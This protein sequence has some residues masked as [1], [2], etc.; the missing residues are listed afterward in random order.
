MTSIPQSS[1]T[2]LPWQDIPHCPGRKVLRDRSEAIDALVR[3]TGT[4]FKTDLAP[5]PVWIAVVEYQ[6]WALLSY[7]KPDGSFK[8]TLNTWSGLLRKCADLGIEPGAIA[9]HTAAHPPS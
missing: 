3:D 1:L 6:R 2:N 5:D 7:E 8:H 9:E 4:W